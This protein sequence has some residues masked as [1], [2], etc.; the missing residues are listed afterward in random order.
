MFFQFLIFMSDN[1]IKCFIGFS[2]NLSQDSKKQDRKTKDEISQ[3]LLKGI[4]DFY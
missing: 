1:F 4:F 3:V 2:V